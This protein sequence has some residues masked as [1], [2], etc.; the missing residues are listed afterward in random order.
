MLP[1][2]TRANARWS[3]DLVSDCLASPA[4]DAFARSKT[5]H[6]FT[7]DRPGASSRQHRSEP[8]LAACRLRPCVEPTRVAPDHLHRSMASLVHHSSFVRAA[9]R[10][11]R[12]KACTQ[13]V[14][15][16]PLK[17][18]AS[19]PARRAVSF[20]IFAM[21]CGVKFA[22][23]RLSCLSIGRKTGPAVMP[24]SSSQSS[25]ARTGHVSG[26]LPYAMTLVCTSSPS[27]VVIRRSS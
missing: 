22:S 21:E 3:M 4:A 6:F 7:R 9:E 23:P 12:Y 5:V 16:C 27:P 26:F 1:T 14:P 17:R 13:R 2:L 18:S 24:A 10:R 8:Q 20:T 25:S 15:E 11:R 19:S